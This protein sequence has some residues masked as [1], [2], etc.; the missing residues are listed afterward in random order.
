MSQDTLLNLT[1]SGGNIV[2]ARDG[3]SPA[4]PIAA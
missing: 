3:E 1:R 4:K 2:R